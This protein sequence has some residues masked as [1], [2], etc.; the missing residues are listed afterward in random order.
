MDG[1]T[2]KF[3]WM[4]TFRTGVPGYQLVWS[5]TDLELYQLC[6]R[7][8]INGVRPG[9]APIRL[10]LVPPEHLVQLTA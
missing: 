5:Y 3:G 2:V 1:E 4:A 6:W 9:V 8:G 10:L 7:A